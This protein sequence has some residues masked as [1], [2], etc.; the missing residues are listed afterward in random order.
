MPRDPGTVVPE[1]LMFYLARLEETHEDFA[2]RHSLEVT[3][4]SKDSR[5]KRVNPKLEMLQRYASAFGTTVADLVTDPAEEPGYGPA[6]L[7]SKG[8]RK[9]VPWKCPQCGA[10][11]ITRVAED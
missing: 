7:P 1:R 4:L 3:K 5:A 9:P 11:L 2:E 8:D 6:A 10:A